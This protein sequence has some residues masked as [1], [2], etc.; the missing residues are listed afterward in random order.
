MAL[1]YGVPLPGNFGP[2]TA[3]LAGLHRVVGRPAARREGS[4]L[5]LERTQRQR[6]ARQ[7][8]RRG[9]R[10][11]RLA[12]LLTR[13]RSRSTR[14]RTGRGPP[15]PEGESAGMPDRTLLPGGSAFAPPIS[16]DPS[17]W[18]DQGRKRY[19]RLRADPRASRWATASRRRP[20]PGLPLRPGVVCRPWAAGAR[21]S[22]VHRHR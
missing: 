12:P 13:S 8:S 2:R 20:E 19:P 4:E 11:G 3:Y 17:W 6:G 14:R 10:G 1:Q 5:L 15:L 18:L 21:G 7:R 22:Q 9:R 16:R